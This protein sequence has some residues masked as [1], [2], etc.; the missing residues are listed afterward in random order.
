MPTIISPKIGTLQN[1]LNLYESDDIKHQLPEY[2]YLNCHICFNTGTEI[3]HTECD[4]LYT[5]ITVPNQP[6]M[7]SKHQNFNNGVFQFVV[8]KDEVVTLQMKPGV[9]FC[10]SGFPL[11]YQ[12]QIYNKA[13]DHPAFMNIVTYN[14]RMVFEHVMESFCR[15]VN[16][17]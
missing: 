5:I 8:D 17:S 14:S 2:G 1:C 12:Q 10:Y 16:E 13:N 4:S 9:S 15:Y 3:D 6:V 7:A 11:T